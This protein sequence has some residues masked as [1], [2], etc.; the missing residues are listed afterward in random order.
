[1]KVWDPV[2]RILH[3]TLVASIGATWFTGEPTIDLHRQAGYAALGAVFIRCTW[4]IV[5]TEHA[6]FRHFVRSA[7]AVR[8]YALDVAQGRESRYIGHNPLGGW[9]VC[10]LLL[11][12]GLVGLT[13]WLYTLDAFWGLA[14]LEWLHRSLAWSLLALIALHVAGVIYTGWRHRENLVAAM[15]TGRKSRPPDESASDRAGDTSS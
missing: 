3:W 6:R 8:R 2:V 15:L 9:M 11:G 5:G 13:G 12:V 7:A 10:A 4:G 14:W 1:L